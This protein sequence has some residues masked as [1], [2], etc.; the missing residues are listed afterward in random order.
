MAFNMISI[1]RLIK[2]SSVKGESKNCLKSFVT[3]N[4]EAKEYRPIHHRRWRL[5]KGDIWSKSMHNDSTICWR[6]MLT[7]TNDWFTDIQGKW[8]PHE[9]NG[10]PRDHLQEVCIATLLR[11]KRY[12]FSLNTVAWYKVC[13]SHEHRLVRR[14]SEPETFVKAKPAAARNGDLTVS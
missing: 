11:S 13:L 6:T 1:L 2:E 3:E 5:S 4:L 12:T 14:T 10:R 8:M 7:N 9:V